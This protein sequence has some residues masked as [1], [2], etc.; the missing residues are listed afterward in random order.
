MQEQINELTESEPDR[1][2]VE[3]TGS[4]DQD[5]EDLAEDPDTDEDLFEDS[6]GMAHKIQKRLDSAIA[7][8]DN[9]LEICE[10][11]KIDAEKYSKEIEKLTN[12]KSLI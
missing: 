8:I 2:I 5:L 12:A 9:M 1:S 11:L 10:Q 7:A 3:P 4:E 6:K